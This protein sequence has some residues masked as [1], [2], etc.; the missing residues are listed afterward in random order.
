MKIKK[1]LVNIILAAAILALLAIVFV[2]VYPKI[3]KLKSNWDVSEDGIL[4]F[5]DYGELEFKITPYS[6]NEYFNITKVEF[7]SEGA[8]IY[9]LLVVPYSDEKLPGLVL[10]PGAGV[11]KESELNLAA[12]IASL[13]FVVLTIDQR[14]VGETGGPFVGIDEDYS[15]FIN[16]KGVFQ[17]LMF[18]DAL[19]AA[20]ILRELASVDRNNIL[21][22]GESLGG[23]IAIIS[24]AIDSNIKGVIGIST[25][26]FG[27]REGHDKKKNRFIKSIDSDTYVPLI[28]PRKLAMIHNIND[29]GIPFQST[30]N[31]YL[32]A[33]EPKIL[34]Y[35]N[36]TSQ[37]CKHGYCQAMHDALKNGLKFALGK[38]EK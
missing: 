38:V 8:K 27:F 28:A 12:T 11:S 37:D 32:K 33:K 23:R 10:L 6:D 2:I 18:Y 5:A 7:K 1:Y 30:A 15:N 24:A 16:N 35:I 34:L 29:A 22:A 9:G 31:T 19:K 26:G 13:G 17:Y 14:G 36:E 21:I 3:I 4:N 25:S 20:K